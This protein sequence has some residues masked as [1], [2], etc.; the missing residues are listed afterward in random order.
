MSV[1]LHGRSKLR[2][3]DMNKI[4]SVKVNRTMCTFICNVRIRRK[5]MGNVGVHDTVYLTI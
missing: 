5:F 1:Y 3:F 2:C 4:I